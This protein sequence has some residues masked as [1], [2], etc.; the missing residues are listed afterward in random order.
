MRI[1]RFTNEVGGKKSIAVGMWMVSFIMSFLILMLFLN[2]DS[3][4]FIGVIGTIILTGVTAIVL[5]LTLQTYGDLLK[6]SKQT[7]TFTKTQT[8]YNRC[9]DNYKL[10]NELS[11]RKTSLVYSNE[12]IYSDHRPYFE[13]LTFETLDINVRNILHN[14]SALALKTE[15]GREVISRTPSHIN[16]KN[17]FLRFSSKIQ[18]FINMI[19][20]EILNIRD[21]EDL[22]DNQKLSL[23]ELYSNYILFDYLN[24]AEE[25]DKEIERHKKEP[26][27]FSDLLQCNSHT[28]KV[29]S[30]EFDVA[31]FLFLYYELADLP[32]W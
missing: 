10:F 18:A 6:V 26:I 31:D 11:K 1:I 7:L 2:P 13:N 28:E 23:V 9:L 30:L 22:T 20:R 24:L 5:F 25:L 8:S 16:Y 32:D 19:H 4:N 17:V 15:T 29:E 12:F 14:Y 21:D 3:I 27:L